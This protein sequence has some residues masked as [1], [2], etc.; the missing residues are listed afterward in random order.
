MEQSEQ[1]TTPDRLA[2]SQARVAAREHQAE[3]EQ[4]E[5]LAKMFVGMG[6][7]GFIL[8]LV[9][10]LR[11]ESSQ[12]I[13]I[14]II[15]L[16]ACAATFVPWRKVLPIARVTAPGGYLGWYAKVAVIG[17]ISFLTHAIVV[18]EWPTAIISGSFLVAGAGIWLGFRIVAL[19]WY[20]SAAAT[21]STVAIG[22]F[23]AF[24]SGAAVPSLIGKVFG[25]LFCWTIVAN[26]V[27]EVRAWSARTA[28]EAE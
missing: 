9:E 11:G 18:A 2:I 17:G 5:L 14:P 3:A 16:A 21:A 6:F 13:H 26:M 12:G 27:F 7:L 23:A 10:V 19:L 15:G 8:L 1:Q 24:Q 20:A 28:E 22:L 4:H 25:A